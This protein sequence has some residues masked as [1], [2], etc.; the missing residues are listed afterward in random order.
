MPRAAVAAAIASGLR[1]LTVAGLA[2]AQPGVAD[3]YGP[4]AGPQPAADSA[5]AFALR[6]RMLDWPGKQTPSAPPPAES[7]PRPTPAAYAT[8]RYA[9]VRPVRYAPPA[10][11]ERAPFAYS[12]PEPERMAYRPPAP[13]EAAPAD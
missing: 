1:A 8:P 13:A 6:G 10:S 2:Q 3:R 9:P 11:P 5:P 4:A 7:A 12:P